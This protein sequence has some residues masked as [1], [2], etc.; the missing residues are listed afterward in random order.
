LIGK[1]GI[2]Q[3]SVEKINKMFLEVW[4]CPQEAITI[5]IEAKL[6]K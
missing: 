1:S 3:A 5:S 2:P 4:G 6:N